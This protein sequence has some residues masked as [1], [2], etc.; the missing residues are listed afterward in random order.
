MQFNGEEEEEEEQ[1]EK[2]KS[3]SSGV[4]RL[5]CFTHLKSKCFSI[6]VCVTVMRPL[7]EFLGALSPNANV[8]AQG[9]SVKP[10]LAHSPLGGLAQLPNTSIRRA[11]FNIYYHIISK[12]LPNIYF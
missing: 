8:W 6:T 1:K 3:Y 11:C 2:Q 7:V 9:R 10:V 5:S 12:L 4:V